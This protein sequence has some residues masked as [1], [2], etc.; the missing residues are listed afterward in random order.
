MNGERLKENIERLEGV[1]RGGSNH[2]FIATRLE[3]WVHCIFGEPH[4][5]FEVMTLD[6]F[7]YSSM[8]DLRKDARELI[9]RLRDELGE[10]GWQQYFGRNLGLLGE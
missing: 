3:N 8:D 5:S 10:E 4:R 7:G 1:D 2:H 9:N 6:Y